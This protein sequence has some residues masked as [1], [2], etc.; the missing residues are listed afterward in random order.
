MLS[1]HEWELRND[2]LHFDASLAFAT[3]RHGPG[4]LALGT[5]VYVLL[6]VFKA[7]GIPEGE[8]SCWRSAY[9]PTARPQT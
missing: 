4:G 8:E 7:L 3:T 5:M 9:R 1:Q 2:C 6:A